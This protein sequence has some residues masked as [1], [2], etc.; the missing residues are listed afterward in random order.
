MLANRAQLREEIQVRDQL[1]IIPHPEVIHQLIHD[2]EQSVLRKP[3]VEGPHHLG[4]GR[5]QR[6]DFPF[7][8]RTQ[9]SAYSAEGSRFAHLGKHEIF[10]PT[11]SYPP[12]TVPELA[13]AAPGTA[14][15][16]L[17]NRRTAP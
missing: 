11:R 13:A 16:S 6:R 9:S 10:T 5:F 8:S 2:H 3:L 7:D 4:K 15:M 14:E 17:S 1:L 12:M